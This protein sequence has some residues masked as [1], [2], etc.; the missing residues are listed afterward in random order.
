MRRRWQTFSALLETSDLDGSTDSIGPAADHNMVSGA[1]E[2]F[3]FLESW[4]RT[5][6]VAPESI[7]GPAEAVTP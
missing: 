4:L 5:I 6:R 2:T 3:R 7:R 1:Q